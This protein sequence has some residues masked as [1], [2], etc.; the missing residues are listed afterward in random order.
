MA[1]AACTVRQ[2]KGEW[3]EFYAF[4]KLLESGKV[5]V[6]DKNSA[7]TDW[8]AVSSV[9]KGAALFKIHSGMVYRVTGERIAGKP[10]LLP[11]G[12]CAALREPVV[13]LLEAISNGKGSFS[14]APSEAE[15]D[16]LK[17]PVQSD[18]TSAKGDLS[19]RFIAPDTMQ[20]SVEMGVS[21]K[22]W[23]GNDPTLLNASPLGTRVLY[24]I[25]GLPEDEILQLPTAPGE[26]LPRELISV[27]HRKGGHLEYLK[28]HH[29]AFQESLRALR[30]DDSLAKAIYQYFSKDGSRRHG[31]RT[32]LSWVTTQ[33]ETPAAQLR[34]KK[35]LKDVLRAAALGMTP[36]TPWDGDNTASDNYLVVV[37]DGNLIFIVGR[38]RLEDYLFESAYFDSPSSRRHKFGFVE[39]AHGDWVV[40]LNFQLRL[41]RF[42][43]V[44]K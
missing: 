40:V 39:K 28:F 42:D 6:I 33:E 23:L 9:R 4:L 7:L 43:T 12:P 36:S 35:A 29:N 38:E 21:V 24:R 3:S 13:K 18:R 25:V 31:N 16:R 26:I 37:R 20:E 19:L 10:Q 15:A 27:I 14:H 2:N 41:E 5:K 22:S 34:M 17:V 8:A 30:A 11:V 44:L 32:K 1:R